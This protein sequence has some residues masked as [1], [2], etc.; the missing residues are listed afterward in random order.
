LFL[1]VHRVDKQKKRYCG[2]LCGL[3]FDKK[4]NKALYAENDIEDV[5]DAEIDHVDIRDVRFCKL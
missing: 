4:I 5:F 3:G 2:V 1:F